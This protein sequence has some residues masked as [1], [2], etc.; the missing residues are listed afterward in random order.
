MANQVATNPWKIDSGALPFSF[1]GM[2]HAMQFEMIRYSNV[3]DFVEV[4][5][6]NGR[7]IAFIRGSQDLQTVRSAWRGWVEGVT[8]PALDSLGNTNLPNGSLLIYFE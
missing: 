8:V 4:Q 5:D 1:D 2:V 6:R 3:T 7:V